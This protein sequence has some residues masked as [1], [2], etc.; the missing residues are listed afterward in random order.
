MFSL[1]SNSNIN[2]NNMENKEVKVEEKQDEVVIDIPMEVE[3][4]K[5]EKLKDR[6][7]EINKQISDLSLSKVNFLQDMKL[8]ESHINDAW[9]YQYFIMN[10]LNEKDIEKVKSFLKENQENTNKLFTEI[11][12]TEC[13][14][15]K[16]LNLEKPEKHDTCFRC[17]N[18]MR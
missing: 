13:D 8:Q 10:K 4:S 12:K 11:E 16:E 15:Y 5:C 17:G 9:L 3:K 18:K 7:D 2:T 6:L 1:F 14:L